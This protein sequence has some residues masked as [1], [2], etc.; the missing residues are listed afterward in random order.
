METTTRA[1]GMGRT[2]RA[3][4]P[5]IITATTLGNAL[6]FFDFT[7]YGFM[8]VVIGKVFFPMMS[9]YIQLLLSVA[10]F[11][12]GFIMRPLGALLIG[13]YADRAG[14][15]AA[16]TL[17]IFLMALGCAMIGLTPSYAQIGLAAPLVV[18][19]ARML[20]GF[21]AGGEVGASTTLLVEY[22]TPSNR[23][24][25]GSWQFASQGLG[26]TL[27]A[28][29]SGGVS[30]FLSPESLQ[31]WGWR[32]PFLLGIL[33]GPLGIFIRRR[34]DE[35]HSEQHAVLAPIRTVLSGH[36]RGILLGTL[37][38]MGSTACAYITTFYMPTYAI[39]E[40]HLPVP[41]ALLAAIWSGALTF[42]FAPLSGLLSDRTSR[43]LLITISRVLT[44]A[45]IYPGFLWL[46]ANPSSV[47][48][49]TVVGVLS[50]LLAFQSAP[51]ITM[52]PEI[53][54]QAVRATGMSIVYGTGVAIFGGFAPFIA[55]WLINETG[56]K[57]APAWYVIACV[58]VSSVALLI[59]KDRTG[60][61]LDT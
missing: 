21:S 3:S 50:V 5:L 46:T 6:E 44:L 16:M 26:V 53:F 30:Y 15:K 20:Q 56:S 37:L 49:L 36:W 14:R 43:K 1:A 58:C 31:S 54:P 25:L 7:V 61:Q 35:T 51:G 40:L 10:T 39:R 28:L 2:R 41:V 9:S 18:V 38:T 12:V 13:A 52:L 33:I 8:A 19:L 24:F 48:L 4:Q 17:T 22:A 23:G 11:G 29:C 57:L 59:L 27:G 34:L 42:I 60:E 47:S 45:L 55:T 32:V